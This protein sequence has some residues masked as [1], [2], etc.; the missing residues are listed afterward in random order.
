MTLV[1]RAI[2]DLSHRMGSHNVTGFIAADSNNKVIILAYSGSSNLQN[3]VNSLGS[4]HMVNWQEIKSVCPNCGVADALYAARNETRDAINAVLLSLIQNSPGYDV[5]ITGHAFGAAHAAVA[6]TELRAVNKISAS[7][8]CKK[9]LNPTPFPPILTRDQYTYGQPRIGNNATTNLINT[10]PNQGGPNYA[11]N[12]RVTHLN[13]PIPD[14]PPYAAGGNTPQPLCKRPAPYPA[15]ANDWTH[16]SPE[17]HIKAGDSGILPKDVE[18][19][20]GPLNCN[21]NSG[22][23]ALPP[24]SQNFCAKANCTANAHYFGCTN[25][26]A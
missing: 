24:S 17:Y 5:I 7:L 15:S 21:G 2:A 26:N 6:A 9:S 10:S 4:F 19:L 25:C 16:S 23:V 1:D 12:Y 20:T 22:L 18:T 3:D 14:L 11:G 13:D 8:V